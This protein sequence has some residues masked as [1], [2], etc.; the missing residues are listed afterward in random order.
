MNGRGAAVFVAAA[1]ALSGCDDGVSAYS[2]QDVYGAPGYYGGPTYASPA[3]GVQPG[4]AVPYG[5]QPGYVAPYAYG[6]GWRDRDHWHDHDFH[7]GGGRSFDRSSQGGRQ[8]P[9]PMAM[10][11]RGPMPAAPMAAP[12]PA[13]APAAPGRRGGVEELGFRPSR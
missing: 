13:R 1:L 9:P 12:P 10:Q 11:P 2:Q 7:D 3:Y 4:Y 5:Y 8:A 6:P